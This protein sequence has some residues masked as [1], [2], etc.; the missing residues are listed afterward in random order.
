MTSI[1]NEH[2]KEWV[3]MAC[4]E[5]G[6]PEPTKVF[7]EKVNKRLPEGV[8][9]LLGVGIKEG[10][11]IT[12]GYKFSLKGLSPNKGP[13]SWFSRY[14]STKEPNPNWEY[15]IQVALYCQLF[16]TAKTKGLALTFEDDL[17]DLAVYDGKKLAVCIEVKEKATHIKRLISGIKK[18]QN[19]VDFI[20]PDR[21]NDPLRK[22]KYIV[23]RRPEYF[24]G[25]AIGARFDYKVTF[26]DN[27]AFRLESDIIPWM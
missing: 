6:Y 27:N 12:Q 26:L 4:R 20:S 23:N 11:I 19:G 17:M 21:G 22:A 8:R 1:F 25:F 9:I 15:Y 3:N 10:I 13:Y 7:Y 2:F 5:W 16:F 24:C 14:S 18:Y